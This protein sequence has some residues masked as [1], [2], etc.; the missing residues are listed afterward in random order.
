MFFLQRCFH[1]FVQGVEAWR[2]SSGLNN[3]SLLLLP[4]T[5]ICL[6]RKSEARRQ[7]QSQPDMARG[8]EEGHSRSQELPSPDYPET[9][10]QWNAAQV[11]VHQRLFPFGDN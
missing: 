10:E 9:S 4:T 6:L 7:N 3:N 8:S 2:W 5:N 1:Y 11:A